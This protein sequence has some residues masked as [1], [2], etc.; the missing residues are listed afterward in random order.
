MNIINVFIV[1]A[2]ERKVLASRSS[3]GLSILF[4]CLKSHSSDDNSV[5]INILR[6]LKCLSEHQYKSNQT[7]LS[8]LS[9]NG[10]ILI[11]FEFLFIFM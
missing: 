9:D 4:D 5:I 8:L 10:A 7:S 11:L 3:H 1:S 6:T 2:A